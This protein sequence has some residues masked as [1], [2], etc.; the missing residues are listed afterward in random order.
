L[1]YKLTKSLFH[2]DSNGIGT[3]YKRVAGYFT[4]TV[5]PYIREKMGNGY[6]HV[7]ESVENRD[8]LAGYL[9]FVSKLLFVGISV[10]FSNW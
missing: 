10:T 3:I 4:F 2:V 7:L 9:L 8:K 5:L 6:T 1:G